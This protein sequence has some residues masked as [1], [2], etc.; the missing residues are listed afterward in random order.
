MDIAGG[1]DCPYFEDDH[2]IFVSLL[3]PQGLAEKSK[4]IHA[5]DKIIEINGVNVENVSHEYAVTL[6]M[7]RKNEVTLKLH[8]TIGIFL[9]AE[10]PT[11]PE[12]T[13]RRQA[14]EATTLR[15][16]PEATILRQASEATILCQ[17]PEATILRQAPEATILRQ[18]PEAT[19][20]CQAPEATI[21]R[22]APEATILRQAPEATI[23]HE[24]EIVPPPIVPPTSTDDMAGFVIGV[25][26]GCVSVMLLKKYMFASSSS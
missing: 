12:A 2:G 22:Q 11:T 4:K 15:Q 1:T 20:L 6:F 24:R 3:K 17:A 21:L 5:E 18:A 19:I 26:L 9:R 14:P 8:K 10:T 13:I 25:A 16:A 23:L 7:I